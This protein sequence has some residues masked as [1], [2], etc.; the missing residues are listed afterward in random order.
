MSNSEL[1]LDLPYVFLLYQFTILH[2]FSSQQGELVGQFRL[3]TTPRVR[4]DPIPL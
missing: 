3:N 1:V 4:I 2:Q